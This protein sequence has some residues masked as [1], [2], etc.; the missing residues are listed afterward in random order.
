[1]ARCGC[2]G[3][4]E[5]VSV[6]NPAC[7]AMS[8]AGTPAD[9]FVPALVLSEDEGNIL[10]CRADGAYVPEL[11]RGVLGYAF[12]TSTQTGIGT[13]E[14]DISGLT[15]AFTAGADRL[16]RVEVMG[17]VGLVSGVTNILGWVKEG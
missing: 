13:S 1:M 12:K 11:G 15:V 2:T 9:P 16:I 14:T 7:V 5:G 6:G 8:G 3:P 10:E 17:R 4:V